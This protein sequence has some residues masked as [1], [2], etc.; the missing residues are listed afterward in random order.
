MIDMDLL[1]KGIRDSGFPFELRV[2]TQLVNLGYDARPSLYFP[3]HDRGKDAELDLLAAKQFK[4]ETASGRKISATIRI[5]VECKDTANRYVCFGLPKQLPREPYEVGVEVYT[6]HFRTSRDQGIKSRY[7]IVLFHPPGKE[8]PQ[9]VEHHHYRSEIRYHSVAIAEAR[10]R[11][12]RQHYRVSSTDS[13]RYSLARLGSYVG[14]S[15][16]HDVSDRVLEEIASGPY[17]NVLF[18]ALVHPEEH[19]LYLREPEEL[20]AASHTPVY[21][22]RSYAGSSLYYIVDLISFAA[23]P[24]AIAKIEA[25]FSAIVSRVIPYMLATDP[26]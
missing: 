8:S 9:V 14:Q 11:G 22:S 13:I 7:N 12:G 24:E 21:L 10:E 16:N 25:S 18:S 23:L 19:Y 1:K 2:A 3:D 26:G 20:K 5:A 4:F 15:G 17:L 6:P